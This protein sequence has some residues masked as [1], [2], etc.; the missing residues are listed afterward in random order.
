[1]CLWFHIPG[2]NGCQSCNRCPELV[3]VT[4]HKLLSISVMIH[5]TWTLSSIQ[6]S[7]FSLAISVHCP[8]W[9]PCCQDVLAESCIRKLVKYSLVSVCSVF[10]CY[11]LKSYSDH[12]HFGLGQLLICPCHTKCPSHRQQLYTIYG[13]C[14][15][16]EDQSVAAALI[17]EG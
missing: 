14:S 12:L 1:M 3:S 15:K 16:A 11:D 7:A 9:S 5:E 6:F 4:W 8:E 17:R 10:C 2:F 13:S